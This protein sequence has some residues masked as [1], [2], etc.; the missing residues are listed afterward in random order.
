MCMQFLP[1]YHTLLFHRTVNSPEDIIRENFVNVK[2]DPHAF[3]SIGY[4]GTRTST[5]PTDF[6]G[7]LASVEMHLKNSTVRSPRSLN[8][9]FNALLVSLIIVYQ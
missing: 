2:R 9:I 5:P 7:L 4:L 3:S 1:G 6:S 8:V